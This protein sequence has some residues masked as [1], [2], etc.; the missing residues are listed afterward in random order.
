MVLKKWVLALCQ[1]AMSDIYLTFICMYLTL[2]YDIYLMHMGVSD[3]PITAVFV[4]TV[5]LCCPWT[6]QNCG[7]SQQHAAENIDLFLYFSFNAWK[8]LLY[9]FFCVENRHLGQLSVRLF[10][11]CSLIKQTLVCIK[12]LH[13]I[14]SFL[15]LNTSFPH[16]RQAF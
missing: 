9:T 4:A 6:L 7:C 8:V 3:S 12:Q 10:I 14:A 16:I 2:L 5:F 11:R 15:Y 13:W 1:H